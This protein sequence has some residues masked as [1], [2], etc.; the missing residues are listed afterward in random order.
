[1]RLVY[2]KYLQ[3]ILT[4]KLTFERCH[5][6]KSLVTQN[7]SCVILAA[8]SNSYMLSEICYIIFRFYYNVDAFLLFT[9]QGKSISIRSSIPLALHH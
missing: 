5:I 6:I 2:T 9:E 3:D 4:S 1:M 7:R 8:A